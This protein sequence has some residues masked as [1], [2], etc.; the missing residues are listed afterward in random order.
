MVGEEEVMGG[1]RGESAG[2]STPAKEAEAMVEVK[3]ELF[4]NTPQQQLILKQLTNLLH[5]LNKTPGTTVEAA[6]LEVWRFFR[7]EV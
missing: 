6:A 5:K 2:H 4:P 1:E 7:R 3:H